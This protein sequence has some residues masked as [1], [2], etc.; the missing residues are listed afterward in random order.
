LFPVLLIFIFLSAFFYISTKNALDDELGKR[1]ATTA[2]MSALQIKPFQLLS[3][4]TAGTQGQT[5]QNIEE[6]LQRL[7]KRQDIERIYIMDVNGQMY[8]DTSG[9]DTQLAPSFERFALHQTE[10]EAVQPGMAQPSVLF[11]GQDGQFYKSAFAPIVDPDQNAVMAIVGVDGNASFFKNLRALERRIIGAGIFFIFIILVISYLLSRKIVNPIDHLV[12]SAQRI[13]DGQLDHEIE[14]QTQNEIGFLSYVMDEMR[15]K[16]IERDQ[17]LQVMLRGIAHEVRNPLGGIELFANL[18]K[19][20]SLDQQDQ[21][22]VDKILFETNNLKKLVDEFLNFARKPALQLSTIDMQE[23]FNDLFFHWSGIFEKQ[24]VQINKEID[25]RVKIEGDRH[26]LERALH[27]LIENALDAM[28]KQPKQLSFLCIYGEKN[29]TLEIQDSGSGIRAQDK[30]KLFQPFFTTKEYGNGL[31]LAM[32]QKIIAA[33][34]G[35]IEIESN[36]NQGT[37]VRIL[38][39]VKQ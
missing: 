28:D 10:I 37:L 20:S 27:N 17:S 15:Q 23:F 14:I 8:L 29:V 4:Q 32:V 35:D 19:E 22:S 11:K 7:E 34:G 5:Y 12:L 16:I 39:P 36:Q 25:A 1:L 9:A 26:H 31:G 33:H 18:L 2:E 21:Q 24:K 30:E 6:K 38:L 3:L 13:G